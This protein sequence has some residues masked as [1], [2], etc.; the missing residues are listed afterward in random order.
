M[1][2]IFVFNK[3][4]SFSFLFFFGRGTAKSAVLDGI[5]DLS[6]HVSVLVYDTNYVH[7]IL[8]CCNIIKWVQKKRQVYDPETEMV[9]DA[10][11]L[12]FN[13]KNS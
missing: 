3:P 2:H 10:Q 11:L 6:G 4:F 8:M 13:V 9:H 7:F 1:L 5:P 12:R